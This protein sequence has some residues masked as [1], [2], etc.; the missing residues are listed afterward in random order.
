MSDRPVER[1]LLTGCYELL[2]FGHLNALRQVKQC[3][4][5]YAPNEYEDLTTNGEVVYRTVPRVH[6]VAGI[7]SNDEIL[8]VKGG[9]CILSEEE[10][11][12]VLLSCKFVDEVAHGIP[13]DTI[14]PDSVDC[15][16]CWHGD[17]E[18]KGS[19]SVLV[20]TKSITNVNFLCKGFLL[21]IRLSVLLSVSTRASLPPPPG[22]PPVIPPS[23][24]PPL[25][26]PPSTTPFLPAP[27]N[28]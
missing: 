17:D 22:S 23:H 13:Y 26:S 28:F 19:Y 15:S 11:A 8:R 7:H 18:V 20:N 16:Y 21:E 10:K 6:V 14:R 1:H 27:P 25:S 24:L 3:Y 9:V 12:R 5:R 4:D 2:H